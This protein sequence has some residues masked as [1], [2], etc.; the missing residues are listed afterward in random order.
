MA[1][2]VLVCAAWPYGNGD[3]HLGH[4]AGAYLPADIFARFERLRGRSVLF[5]SGTDSHGTPITVTAEKEGLRPEDVFRRYH[6]R[7]LESFSRLGISFDLFTHTDTDNHHRVAKDFFIRLE[8]KKLLLPDTTQQFYCE[9][10]RRFLPDRY[11]TGTCPHCGN[12]SAR[13]DQCEACS[14]PLEPTEL[15]Q[16]Q[17][18]LCGRTP[19]L[20]E[21]RHFF[22]DL[23]HFKAQLEKWAAAQT[24]WRPNVY[25]FTLRYLKDLKPRPVTRDIDWGVPVPASGY[26]GKRIYVW[27]EAVIGYLSASEEWAARDDKP[28]AWEAWWKDR[29]ARAYYFIGKDNIPFHTVIWP[30][31]LLGTDGLNLPY[32]VPANE[33]LNLEGRKFSTSQNWAV[34]LPDFLSRYDPDTL[35]FYLTAI[36]PDTQD[37]NFSWADYFRRTND[38]LV[39]TWGNLAHRVLSFAQQRFEG[40]VPSPGPLDPASQ[41]ILS[42]VEGGFPS[43][44]Q[45]LEECKFRLALTE[46]MALAGEANRYFQFQAPWKLIKEQKQ[47][48]AATAVFVGLRVVDSL[49]TLLF[50]FLPFSCQRLHADLGYP[51]N[52]LGTLKIEEFQ[53][54]GREHSVLAYSPEEAGKDH[55]RSSEL[56]PGRALRPPAPLFTKL[57]EGMVDQELERLA[58]AKG[59]N[60]QA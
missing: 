52:M 47:Q 35:R 8:E 33:F 1:E 14:N 43:V 37:S 17:C 44:G 28:A 22:L 36:A 18:R 12:P 21:T 26:E 46:I 20:R 30:A 10:D 5:V 55:W 24:H 40:K 53:D 41:A 45:L 4:V 38:D 19:V 51:E 7:F 54:S 57:E 31:L 48:E 13:G 56:P 59:G 27:F 32:D 60:P 16:P 58:S 25:N 3:L 42:K 29:A 11:V 50:P 2:K 34:W 9:A 49:K 15:K 23:P 39:G 6:R